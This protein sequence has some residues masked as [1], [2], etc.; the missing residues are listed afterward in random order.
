MGGRKITGLGAATAPA[1]AVRFDQIPTITVQSGPYD[2]TAGRLLTPGAYGLG[3]LGSAVVATDIDATMASGSQQFTTGAVG[4]FPVGVT[5][6]NGGKINLVR[7]SVT[8]AYEVLQPNNA[9]NMFWRRL[10]T[11]WQSWQQIISVPDSTVANG[12][13]LA[14]IGGVW[15]R[16][17]KGAPGQMLRQN[18]GLTSPEWT[19]VITARAAQATGSGTAFSFL[20]I[21]SWAK[22]ITF[23][24]DEISLSGS[25]NFLVQIGVAAGFITAGYSG[26][27]FV[28][29]GGGGSYASSAT[30]FLMATNAAGEAHSGH[31]IITRV[32]TSNDW[33]SSHT[34]GSSARLV[35]GG[36][37]ISLG[38]ALTQVRLTR[39]GA[40]TFDA[41]VISITYE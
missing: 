7:A 13:M 39:D 20:T 31:M 35:S 28:S 16:L 3:L 23:V 2:T 4:T 9:D 1:D 26:G 33:V 8:D 14:R 12:D 37:A 19:D 11:T 30:G 15:A 21:P 41:G 29:T 25:D 22:K 18:D 40:N 17:A 24:F 36:G 6:A 34:M 27:S 5:S 32:G 38:A 10:S